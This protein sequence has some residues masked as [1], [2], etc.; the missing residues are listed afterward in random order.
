MRELETE[1]KWCF[2]L[3]IKYF[4]LSLKRSKLRLECLSHLISL[5]LRL[6][7]DWAHGWLPYIMIIEESLELEPLPKVDKTNLKASK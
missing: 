6:L 5:N 3:R 7:Q 1:R 4:P 2:E